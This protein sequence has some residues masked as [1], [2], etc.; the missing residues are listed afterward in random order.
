M[1]FFSI[2]S[3]LLVLTSC[4]N[5]VQDI[6]YG[7]DSCDFCS[8]GIVDQGH[9]SQLVTTKGKN[10]KFDAIECMA[11]Y[12]LKNEE[13]QY[14]YILVAD[15][16]KPGELI[17]ATTAHYIITKNIPSPMG[18]FLS[19]TKEDRTAKDMAS[20]YEGELFSWQQI[21]EKLNSH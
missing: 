2:F 3:L 21:K 9:A 16:A 8:M 1:K 6:N 18:A 14:D 15:L 4:S 10:F 13:V 19:A 11:H 20:E 12:I 17:D 5:K 7:S